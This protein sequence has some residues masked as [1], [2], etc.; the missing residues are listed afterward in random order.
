MKILLLGEY[1]NV[2][3]TL[4]EGLRQLGHEVTVASNGDFWKDYTRDVDLARKPGKVG[5]VCLMAKVYSLLPQWRGFDVVQLI[6]PMFLELKAERILPIYKYLRKHNKKMVL[7]AFGMDWYWV[8]ECTFRKPL[9]Y[10]DFNIGDKVRTDDAAVIEQ[11][12]WLNTPKGRLN[13]TIAND[14]DGIVTGLYEYQVCYEPYFPQKTQFIPYPIKVPANLPPIET[15]PAPV[16]FFIGISKGRNAYKG[17][18]IMLQAAE[19]VLQKYPGRLE[20]I[21]AEGVPFAQYQ[22]MM[23]GSDVLIDQLYSY[24]PAMN[25]L[26][27]MS[28]G[29]I[30][31]GGGEAE[32][33]DI[34]GETE[35][36]PII[37]VEPNFESV[38]NQ[39]EQL[40]LHPDCIQELKR[41]SIEYIRRHHD[42]M[43]VAR[44]YE[45]FYQEL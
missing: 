28:K 44:R 11:R 43:K 42:Y 14:C 20:L 40:V 34:L 25:A 37:N 24:T 45:S 32:N 22:Q 29:I 41:Q 9:R 39:M 38:Y 1:S 21:K 8:N 3:N 17:T 33:Y 2:H 4:A 27:A 10:S 15:E 7:G 16:K 26:L 12:D 35:L 31:I 36:H 5:G 30:C 23:D 19:A 13:Q 18:D 6:N